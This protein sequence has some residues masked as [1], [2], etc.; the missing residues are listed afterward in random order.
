[1]IGTYAWNVFENTGSLDAY[2]LKVEAEKARNEAPTVINTESDEASLIM[3][4]KESSIS[5]A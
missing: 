1:M 2:L 5:T 3:D 4:K